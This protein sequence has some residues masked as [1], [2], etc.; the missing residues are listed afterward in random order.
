VWK[1]AIHPEDRDR[2]LAAFA[3][4]KEGARE[5]EYRIQRPDGSVRWLRDS[6]FPI[7]GAN[8]TVTG[9]AGVTEDITRHRADADEKAALENKLQETQRL[10]SLGVLA[11]GIAHDFNN[12]LTAVLGNASLARMML[13][14][15][16]DAQKYL[17]EIEAVS[18]RAADLC[19]QMLAYSGKGRFDVQLIDLSTLVT[20]TTQLLQ[21]SISKTATL[22][23]DLSSKLPAILADPTQ[24]RQVVMNLVINASEAFD[25]K[26]GTISLRT[27]VIRVDSDYLKATVIANDL[28]EGEYIFLEVADNGQGMSAETQARIFDP[29]FTTKFTGRGLGLSAVLGIVRSHKGALKVYSEPGKGTMF[30]LIFPAVEGKARSLQR[31]PQSLQEWRG[32]G[33]V[34]VVD[35]EE[36]VR[37]ICCRALESFGFKVIAA[38][39]GQEAIAQFAKSSLEIVA[40]LMDLTMP[41]VDGEE[42][43][44]H[45]RLL[46]P[47][48]RVLLMS[49]FNEAEAVSRFIGKGLAGFL[50]KPFK[51]AELRTKLREMLGP[52]F[53]AR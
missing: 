16:N 31:E 39:D 43:F 32:S 49:G 34:L 50:Q 24:L 21:L 35:D 41:N 38:K 47:D 51:P 23:F 10:E 18:L 1:D 4:E 20:E 26:S 46:K 15:D 7:Q 44:R 13:P 29:F 8:G 6:S 53:P 45:L 48:L 3:K 14:P 30:R 52:G 37:T 25:G 12:L 33:T 27:G 11:G 9:V 36:T 5:I 19:R 28:P 42:A 17:S 22:Q 2:V 40:V